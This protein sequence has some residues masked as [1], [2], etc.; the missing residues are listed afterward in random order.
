MTAFPVQMDDASIQNE[1]EPRDRMPCDTCGRGTPAT[2]YVRVLEKKVHSHLCDEHG[3]QAIHAYFAAGLNVEAQRFGE[4]VFSIDAHRDQKKAQ[5]EAFLQKLKGERLTDSGEDFPVY[6]RRPFS[7]EQEDN[8]IVGWSFITMGRAHTV[9]DKHKPTPPDD[10]LCSP[11]IAAD[12]DGEVCEDCF[13]ALVG[14]HCAAC[15]CTVLVDDFDEKANTC[16]ACE[17]RRAIE[18]GEASAEWRNE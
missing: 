18:S 5:V 8:R 14:S 13:D 6:D 10:L 9:C 15:N 3:A 7:V 11:I 2:L 17:R 16:N 12:F 1:F 4:R